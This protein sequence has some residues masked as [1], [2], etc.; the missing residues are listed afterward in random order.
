MPAIVEKLQKP[1]ILIGS[2]LDMV[3][4]NFPEIFS[5]FPENSIN[6]I[7]RSTQQ[8]TLQRYQHYLDNPQS[9]MELMRLRVHSIKNILP[10][11][12]IFK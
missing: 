9:S 6:F 3:E 2:T 1:A 5:E 10:D 11:L 8:L 12:F 7:A 4:S